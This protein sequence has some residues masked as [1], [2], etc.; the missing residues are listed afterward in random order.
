MSD[1]LRFSVIV[2][3]GIHDV[4]AIVKILTLKGFHEVTTVDQIP[5]PFHRIVQQRYPWQ[6]DGQKLTWT[7]SHPSFLVKDNYWV[8]VSNA[9]GKTELANNLKSILAAFLKSFTDPALQSAAMLADADQKNTSEKRL[10][11]FKQLADA[12]AGEDYFEFDPS[13]PKQ[14]RRFGAIKPFDIYIFPDNQG[15]GTLEEVLLDGARQAYP[16]LLSEAERYVAYAKGLPY[17]K[18]LKDNFNDQKATVGVVA[19]ALRPGRANQ[20]SIH[21]NKWFTAQT[22]TDLPLHQTLSH[23]IDSILIQETN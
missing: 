14:I 22:L 6:N 19:N 20:T 5:E 2:S 11:L 10:E 15:T 17:T 12:F 13:T 9:G 7:V 16:E 18:E 21:D 23:F 8:L 4:M 1:D 3:E